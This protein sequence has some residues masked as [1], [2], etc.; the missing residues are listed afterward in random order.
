MATV[1]VL[2]GRVRVEEKLIAAALTEVG[3]SPRPVTPAGLPLPP[4]PMPTPIPPAP[5]AAGGLAGGLLL[6]RG[7]D[8]AVATALLAAARV[9]GAIVLDAGIAA[10][11]D[12]L[13]VASA[14]ATAG[15]PRPTTHLACTEEAALTALA[16]VGYPATLLP[17]PF[18]SAAVALLDADTAEAVVEHRSVLGTGRAALALVQAG[19]WPTTARVRLVVVDGEAVATLPGAEARPAALHIAESTARALGAAM[20]GVDIV[21][22]AGGPVVWDVAPVP[23]FRHATPLGGKTV[24]EAIAELIQRRLPS[25]E[26]VPAPP[27]TVEFTHPGTFTIRL[28][29][30]TRHGVVLSA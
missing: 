4:T 3:V 20:L 15:V 18:G 5:A 10:S 21:Y 13:A 2:C 26:L 28:G 8:R 22:T 23:E 30:E 25:P 9:C 11:G 6:D 29:E 7:Q 19:I 16:D 24:A 12:R 17:L 1:G 27:A 14:L